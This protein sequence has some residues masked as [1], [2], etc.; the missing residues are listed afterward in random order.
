[1]IPFEKLDLNNKEHYDNILRHC[2]ERG[3]EYSFANLFIWGRQKGAFVNGF[4]TLF[5]QFNRKS[6]YP[7]PIGRGDIKPV[8]DAII[9]DAKARGIPCRI[10]SMTQADC[11]LLE[12]LYPGQFRFHADRDSF[13]Y[14]YAIDDLADLKGR[15]LQKK[16]S[17]VNR[18]L[19]DHPNYQVLPL[20]EQTRVDAYCMLQQWYAHRE[21]IDPLNDFYLEK[22]ALERAFAFQT[23]LELEGIVIKEDDRIIAFTMGSPLSE[24]TFDIHF[25][26]AREDIPGA[27]NI[28][29]R[30][31][32]RYL[33]EKYPQLK[34]LNREDDL[35]LEGLRKAKLD[36]R[37]DHMVE[38]YWARLWEDE[39]ET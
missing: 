29:N 26:K 4:V 13:D 6:I 38:K 27:Y 14:V 25:E 36:Y 24:D 30:E 5:S 37:P 39:D 16:R 33:R 31:F 1:M 18:F 9:H 17:H 10:S 21:E 35:G 19:A 7:F 20:D 28:I 23:Q 2:G 12:S 22:R 11:E 3:C 15:K 32:A 34:W 8:L